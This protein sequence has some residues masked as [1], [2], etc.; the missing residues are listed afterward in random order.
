MRARGGHGPSGAGK[1]IALNALAD[2]GYY[3]VDN[4]PV[5]MLGA[6]VE[7]LS[8]EGRA[9]IAVGSTHEARGGTSPSRRSWRR[10][11]PRG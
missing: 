2:L 9:R 6:L 10:Y 4:L 5:P 7:L 11:R 8:S 1:S 3:C